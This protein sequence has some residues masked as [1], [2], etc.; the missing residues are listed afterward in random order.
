M[1][2]IVFEAPE[3]TQEVEAAQ[4]AYVQDGTWIEFSAN[5]QEV[6]VPRSRVYMIGGPVDDSPHSDLG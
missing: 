5:G 1:V 2:R 6:Q 4:I 3:G